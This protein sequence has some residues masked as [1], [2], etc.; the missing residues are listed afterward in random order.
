MIQKLS[1]IVLIFGMTLFFLGA[2]AVTLGGVTWGWVNGPVLIAG[3]AVV[4]LIVGAVAVVRI[5]G[6]MEG[7]FIRF[8]LVWQAL[9]RIRSETERQEMASGFYRV[10]H[11]SAGAAVVDRNGGFFVLQPPTPTPPG[12][13]KI[14]D[15]GRDPEP[16]E[17]IEEP[18]PL[19]SVM[20]YIVDSQS[21]ILLGPQ[22]AGKTTLMSHLIDERAGG[23][24]MIAV[25]DPH[26]YE[27]KYPGVAR[28]I[29]ASRSY[30]EI[31]HFFLGMLDEMQR[32]YSEYNGRNSWTP[33]SIF[34]DEMTLVSQHVQAA[35]QFMESALT[36]FRKA[37]MSLVL[38]LH[39]RRAKFL[40]LQG[41][42][43]LAEGVDYCNLKKVRQE[44]WAELELA[45]NDEIIYAALPGPY[46]GSGRRGPG[47][48]HR[49]RTQGNTADTGRTQGHRHGQ[50]HRPG[51]AQRPMSIGLSGPDTSQ[52][53]ERTQDTPP[54]HRII[55]EMWRAGKSFNQIAKEIFGSRGGRQTKEI[56]AILAN[57]GLI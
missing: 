30:S 29:G 31:D 43:D 38:C 53:R 23:G 9:R 22:N 33:I 50:T 21:L 16:L 24:D 46:G 18:E 11:H 42:F 5:I 41:A 6:A 40:N 19:P 44:R 49:H 57:Y 47:Q 17:E 34:V 26:G 20:D 3:I 15:Q 4:V 8:M 14:A 55:I 39:S 52:T 48:T 54:T 2:V 37:H 45:G 28:I 35:K 36:E 51:R 27:G 1:R 32:R 13:G 10:D 7:L 12:A 56:K 25:V